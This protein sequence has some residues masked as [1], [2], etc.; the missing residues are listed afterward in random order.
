MSALDAESLLAGAS[1][2]LAAGQAAAAQ[3]KCLRVLSSHPQHPPALQLLGLVLSAQGHYEQAARVFNALT[4][5]QPDAAVHWE[6]LGTALRPARHYA[7]ALAA[8][9][10]AL[11]LGP[12]SPGLL[13]NLGVLQMDRCDYAA[14]YLALK[15]AV[16]LAPT[17]GPIRWAF[18]QCCYDSARPEEALAALSGWEELDGLSVEFTVLIVLLL[19]MLGAGH[20]AQRAIDGLLAHP[21][22]GG[23]AALGLASLLERLHRLDEARAALERFERDA[24][25]RGAE[26]ERML[27]RA[28]LAERAGEHEEAYRQLVAALKMQDEFVHRHNLLFP[29]ARVCDALGRYAEAYAVAEE[30]HR[31][32]LAFLE[33]ATGKSF[34]QDSSVWALTAPS[35]L[36]YDIADWE[37]TG[38]AA[39]DSPIFI[40]GFPRSGTTLLEQVLDAH[41]LLQSM[42]EQPLLLNAVREI[43]QRGIGYPGELHRLAADAR[44]QIRAQ[45]WQQ[46]RDRGRLLP[47]RQLVDKNPLNLILAPLIKAL[48]PHARLVLAIR[49][50]C[51]TVLSCF[52][53]R[54]RSPGLAV[55]CRDLTTLARAYSRSFE[56][57][58]SQRPLL[59]PVHYELRYEQL[60]ED[61]AGEVRRLTHFLQLPWHEALL[62][63]AAHARAKGFI[64][65]PSYAQ[66]LEPVNSRSVGRW[67]N[68][69]PHFTE[70]VL[71]LLTS[72]IGRWG[73]SLTPQPPPGAQKKT[74]GLGPPS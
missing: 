65:T 6:H 57:W 21:P 56:Y 30:A 41:P 28:V 24:G 14:A 60:T 8:F 29:L 55:L 3:E 25:E 17:D 42:D 2:D 51:D 11:Q 47:S 63:P 64:S 34:A 23:R 37:A 9:E 27:L 5:I 62:A 71:T 26:P 4:L 44:E 32:Q 39:Q 1:Q 10:R 52:L 19:V 59:H 38:P 68:Y 36:E 69:R 49:H 50:P 73:Y 48:F 66:V 67:E 43:S 72:W 45:Y 35:Q 53:Q 12:P 16:V 74:A 58:Y 33:R 7:Q 31:S 46:A 13:Y 18:A 15:D 70:E 40:V 54:F 22:Q 20:L 61:F